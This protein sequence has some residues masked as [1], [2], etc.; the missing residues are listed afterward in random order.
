[1]TQ[2]PKV[3]INRGS[4]RLA[5]APL[6]PSCSFFR[7]RAGNR[8]CAVCVHH[9]SRRTQMAYELRGS[10]HACTHVRIPPRPRNIIAV[11]RW[12]WGS[13]ALTRVLGASTCCVARVS[14]HV[15]LWP[16]PRLVSR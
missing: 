4:M 14:I 10:V 8:K 7:T 16:L 3:M 13:L 11:I 9:A 1:M 6:R 2:R 12:N 15:L 5:S